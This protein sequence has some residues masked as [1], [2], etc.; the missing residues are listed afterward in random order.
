M[1]AHDAIKEINSPSED[2]CAK[3][4]SHETSFKCRSFDY[5]ID[6]GD[7]NLKYTCFLHTAHFMDNIRNEGTIQIDKKYAQCDHYSRNYVADFT[8]KPN[9]KYQNTNGKMA[10]TSITLEQ[11]AYEC[12]E[13]QSTKCVGFAFCQGQTV[14]SEHKEAV[15][16]LS[17]TDDRSSSVADPSCTIYTKGQTKLN[18]DHISSFT[19]KVTKTEKY[20]YSS[21]AGAGVGILMLIIGGVVAVG[22]IIYYNKRKSVHV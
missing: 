9:F 7:D 13:T 15:C 2:D 1:L 4:C 14:T 16:Y 10:L 21:G 11:C 6:N 5:C 22:G 20:A 3:A 12:A 19:S 8:S 18:P 17:A